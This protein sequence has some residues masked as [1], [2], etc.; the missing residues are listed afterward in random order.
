MKISQTLKRSILIV[1]ISLGA[2]VL[3]FGG[4]LLA[5]ARADRAQVEALF[6]NDSV[7][8]PVRTIDS[9]VSPDTSISMMQA[10]QENS[11]QVARDVLPVV[12]QIDVLKKV[13]NQQNP[14]RFFFNGQPWP[15]GNGQQDEQTP[16]DETPQYNGSGSGIIIMQKA[17]TV[18][19]LTNNH[20]VEGA[21]KYTVRTY[22]GQEYDA[23]VVGT[24][25]NRDIAVLSFTNPERMSIARLGNSD[26]VLPGDIVYAVGS[27]YAIQNTITQGI[28]SAVGRNTRDLGAASSQIA[29]FTDYLQTDAAINP[30]NSG[31]ALV[32]INGEVIGVN[33]WI[34]TR[35][36][37]NVGL[38]F[39]VPINNAKK[40]AMDFILKGKVEYGWLGVAPGNVLE[41]HKKDLK[42]DSTQGALVYNI[43][44]DSPAD[45][46]G[47]KPGDLILEANNKTIK[48]ADDLVLVISSTESN[49]QVPLKI[50]RDGKQQTVNVTLGVRDESVSPESYWP[51]FT[52]LPLDKDLKAQLKT[53]SPEGTMIV[54]YVESGTIAG[55]TGLKPG[56]EI[57]SVN[58][59]R[60]RNTADFYQAVNST[61]KRFIKM[62]IRRNGREINLSWQG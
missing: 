15:N 50:I 36:G 2:A 26:T 32:N 34:A 61:D 59:K 13:S 24:D 8:T 12:V 7:S 52:A 39:S 10:F 5:N 16:K 27:P 44:K 40:V 47:V 1:S 21:D 9:R 19:V 33:T 14:F 6:S 49:K 53:D 56:D 51:G 29:S 18:Y 43:I 4:F 38:G 37:E 11:R 28:I 23:Q 25:K 48:T 31:G 35:T 20:V 3:F 62:T 58:D 57:V 60:I 55:D 17:S 46:A 30:G 42:L 45:T 22:S 41:A 54:Y